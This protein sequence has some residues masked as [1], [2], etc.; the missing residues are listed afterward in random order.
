MKKGYTLV[1]IIIALTIL[2][3][4]LVS[5]M[6]YLP[7]ALNAS[8][9]AADR[10]KATLIAQGLIEKIKAESYDDITDADSFDTG[11]YESVSG[12]SGFEY[13][14]EVTPLGVAPAKDI[15][16]SVRW[17][18]KGKANSETFQTKI[19]KYNPT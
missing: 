16:I 7:V 6:A 17:Q 11:T 2:G 12:Y 15:N 14:I 10:T 8:R 19:V 4:G 13:K 18:F 1:E 5:V 9:K 3:I